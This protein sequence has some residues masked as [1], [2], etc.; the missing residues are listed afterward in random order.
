MDIKRAIYLTTALAAA[1]W[2]PA[3]APM[4]QNEVP[5]SCPSFAPNARVRYGDAHLQVDALKKVRP[6]CPLVFKLQPDSTRGPNGLN[7]D[8]VKVTIKGK[9]V[10]GAHWIDFSGTAAGT[11]GQKYVATSRPDQAEGTYFYLV[12]VEKVGTL[13]PRVIVEK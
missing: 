7:Y 13:D 6:G 12:T 4:P 11:T 2:L 9:N 8:D 1:A 5:L 3:C 10:D